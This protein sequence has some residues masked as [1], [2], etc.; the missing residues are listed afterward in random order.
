VLGDL[1]LNTADIGRRPGDSGTPDA[2]LLLG[3]MRIT[4]Q[5]SLDETN[6]HGPEIVLKH[7]RVE[8]RLRWKL[9][10]TEPLAPGLLVDLMQTEVG[11]LHDD[12]DQW[13]EA[14]SRLDGFSFDGVAVRGGG[15]KWTKKRKKWLI[16]QW[17]G[18][19]SPY[20]YGQL[21]TALQSAG[22][23]REARNIAIAREKARFKMGR[24]GPLSKLA[25]GLYWLLLGFGYKPLQ[26]FLIAAAVV[27]GF[28]FVFHGVEH[29][30][31]GETAQQCGGF[32][33]PAAHSPPFNSL[34]FSLDA[35]A[36]IDL[37]QTAAWRPNA[38][39]YASMVAVETSLGWLFAGLLVGA[40]TGILRRD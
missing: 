16:R 14:S 38:A 12:L 25:Q 35:F 10:R 24:L 32:A 18:K 6:F 30:G 13:H 11:Y 34:L 5:L 33:F 8:G 40:V 1:R 4:G 19:W 31:L 39:G 15:R 9:R 20:P 26:F 2:E 21:R 37:G 3:A 23:E 27:V 17:E 28:S 22:Y 36:P 29:C 7:T